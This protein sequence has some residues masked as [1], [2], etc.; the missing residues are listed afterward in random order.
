MIAYRGGG[1]HACC[2]AGSVVRWR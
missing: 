1:I 2:T